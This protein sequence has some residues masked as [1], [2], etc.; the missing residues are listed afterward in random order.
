MEKTESLDEKMFF[1]V[2]CPCHLYACTQPARVEQKSLNSCSKYQVNRL[3]NN[4]V[5]Q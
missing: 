1:L 3:S 2:T 4:G 5:F